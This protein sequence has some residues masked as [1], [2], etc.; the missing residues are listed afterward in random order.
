MNNSYIPSFLKDKIFIFFNYFIGF[1]SLI[2]SILLAL[3]L[4][5]FDINDNSFLTN[6]SSLSSNLLGDIGSYIAS[7]IFYAFGIMGFGLVIFF[8]T[9]AISTFRRKRPEFFFIRLLFFLVSLTLIPQS[10]F[11]LNY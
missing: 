4:I 3:S 2:L 6:S 1:L 10:F 11:Y 5:T 7:F 9:Y 8:F